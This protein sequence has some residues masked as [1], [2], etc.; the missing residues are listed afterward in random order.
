LA[1][2]AV[3]HS[4]HSVEALSVQQFAAYQEAVQLYAR[5]DYRGALA[6]LDRLE[7]VPG[8]TAADRAFLERQREIC[9]AAQG[10]GV[11]VFTHSGGQATTPSPQRVLRTAEQA[12]CGPRALLIVC[13]KLGIAATLADLRQ[14]ASTTG[15][16]T[17]LAGLAKAARAEG[18]KPEGIHVD[19]DALANLSS[20]ALAWVDGDHYL[21]VLSVDGDQATIHDPNKRDE[22]TIPTDDLLR[23][24]GGILLTL[25]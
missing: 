9:E 17:T 16:G 8:R 24:S 10:G 4:S 13:R 5:H 25:R 12:D 20:T 6:A 7:A 23:R 3:A 19:R 21:A 15:G 2:K 22:E 14:K 1:T 11:R 18:L